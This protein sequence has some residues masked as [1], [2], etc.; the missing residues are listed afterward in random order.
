MTLRLFGARERRRVDDRLEAR[1]RLPLRLRRAVVVAEPRRIAADQRADLAGLDVDDHDRTFGAWSELHPPRPVLELDRRFRA[2]IVDISLVDFLRGRHA[3]G[4]HLDDVADLEPLARLLAVEVVALVELVAELQ[5][6]RVLA[7]V[8]L[9]LAVVVVDRGHDRVVRRPRLQHLAAHLLAESR[10][11][12]L[13]LVGLDLA[14]RA[15]DLVARIDGAQPCL[16]RRDRL[17]LQ[18]RIERGA[19]DRALI[20]C[21]DLLVGEQLG[22]HQID[23]FR[24][25]VVL[26][27]RLHDLDLRP[28]ATSAPRQR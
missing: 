5:H 23:P 28:R 24:G 22:L 7:E 27:G 13:E 26:D 10:E 11:L 8:D 20:E 19:D 9:E 17:F 21:V 4:P 2:R 3:G 6:R 14:D 18:T 12:G 25:R 15:A 1:A 16:Q